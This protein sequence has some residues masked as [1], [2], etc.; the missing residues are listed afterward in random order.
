VIDQTAQY[1][2]RVALTEK[3]RADMLFGVRVDFAD[4]TGALKPGLPVTV[5][6]SGARSNERAATTPPS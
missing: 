2:P 6:F 3:E 1:S 4:T 5:R